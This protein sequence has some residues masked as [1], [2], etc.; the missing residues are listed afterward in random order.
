MKWI[1]DAIR[2]LEASLHPV[3]CELNALDWKS[4]LSPKSE[5]LAQHMSAFANNEGGGF[6][7]FGVN[8]D[9]TR[10][11]IDQK[12]ADDIVTKLGNIAKNNLFRPIKIEHILKDFEGSPVLFVHV[13]EQPDKPIYLRGGDIYD[14]Y[15]RSAGSTHKMPRQMVANMIAKSQGVSFEMM[16][17]KENISADEISKLINV[18][19]FF[20]MIGKPMPEDAAK[21]A[22]QCS[23]YNLCENNGERWNITNLG[24]LLFAYDFRDFRHLEFKYIL[25]RQYEGTN[26]RNLISE[27][28]FYEGYAVSLSKIVEHTMSLLPKKEII[29]KAQRE[30]I[31]TYPEVAIRELAAN[32]QIHQ[33]FEISGMSNTIE[34][35]TNRLTITN[36]GAPLID[37]DRFIDMPPKSRNEKLAQAMFLFNLCE[38]RGSGMDRAVEGIEKLCLPAIKVEKGDEF[39]RV[40]MYPQKDYTQMTKAEKVLACYQHA[41]LLNEDGLQLTNQSLRERLGISK[42]NSATASRII[43]EA[44]DLGLIKPFDQEGG[45]KKFSSYIPFYA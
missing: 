30:N 45:S 3:P 29:Q 2:N 40:S 21:I 25:V 36:P 35:F 27:K 39:T 17:A 14:S 44:V 4:G 33:N 31:P 32:M 16:A 26:N 24:A 38:R 18:R 23:N 37:T 15:Y 6:F 8:N 34:I 12:T 41:C 28:F 43:S 5:R 20:R 22:E 42:N 11:E 7:A 10:C 13:P 1:E 9:A 19:E